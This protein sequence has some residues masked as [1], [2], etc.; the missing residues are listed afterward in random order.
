MLAGKL[1]LNYSLQQIPPEM[2]LRVEKTT[3]KRP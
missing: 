3:A 2:Q 1:V